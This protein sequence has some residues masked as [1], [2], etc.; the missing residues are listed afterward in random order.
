MD[1]YWIAI[2]AGCIS[3]ATLLLSGLSLRR[4]VDLDYVQSL[5]HRISLSEES[6][7]R[8]RESES[9]LKKLVAGLEMRNAELMSMIISIKKVAV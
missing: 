7:S 8:C 2:A 5:E 1:S 6:L 9:E 4:K 3:V